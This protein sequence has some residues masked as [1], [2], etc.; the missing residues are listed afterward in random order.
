MTSALSMRMKLNLPTHETDHTSPCSI[1]NKMYV[2]YHPHVTHTFTAWCFR[3]RSYSLYISLCYVAETGVLVI[4]S[5]INS[6]LDLEHAIFEPLLQWCHIIKNLLLFDMCHGSTALFST[7]PRFTVTV[8]WGKKPTK[9]VRILSPFHT[10]YFPQ[11]PLHWDWCVIF[12]SLW[13]WLAHFCFMKM[14]NIVY[15]QL[16]NNFDT[17]CS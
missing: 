2:K 4:L 1:V 12:V 5:A 6:L 10:K 3:H 16:W 17:P 9:I 8:L 14:T 11:C 13:M 7:S 15:A